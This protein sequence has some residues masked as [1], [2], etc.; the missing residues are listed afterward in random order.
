MTVFVALAGLAHRFG[1]PA[2]TFKVEPLKSVPLS[3]C[4]FEVH[5]K[6]ES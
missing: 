6:N 1:F 2:W 4:H 3:S 5:S